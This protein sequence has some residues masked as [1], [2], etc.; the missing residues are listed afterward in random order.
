MNTSLNHML[1]PC[2]GSKKKR[3]IHIVGCEYEKHLNEYNSITFKSE[4][5]AIE[6]GYT[7]YCKTC[8]P[9]REICKFPA[10][11]SSFCS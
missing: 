4:K 6:Q 2:V 11:T 9:G 7:H 3:T 8:C 5:E 10:F 1:Y